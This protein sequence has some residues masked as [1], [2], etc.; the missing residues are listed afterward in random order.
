VFQQFIYSLPAQNTFSGAGTGHVSGCWRGSASD[1]KGLVLLA[2]KVFLHFT[3]GVPRQLGHDK[4]AF[5]NFE[6]RQARLQVGQDG[7]RIKG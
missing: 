4:T 7:L 3:H 5:G 6:I 2:Q 1:E